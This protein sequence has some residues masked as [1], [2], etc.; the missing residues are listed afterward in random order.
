MQL[1]HQGLGKVR[2]LDTQSLWIQDAV[3]ERRVRLEKVLGT[4]NPADMFTKHIDGTLREKL[5]KK[6]GLEQRGGRAATAPQLVRGPAGRAN[7]DEQVANIDLFEIDHGDEIY[8]ECEAEVERVGSRRQNS[9]LKH[10]SGDAPNGAKRS[11]ASRRRRHT[12]TSSITSFGRSSTIS[13][14]SSIG[15]RRFGSARGIAPHESDAAKER[16]PRSKAT[17]SYRPGGERH[18]LSSLGFTRAVIRLWQRSCLNSATDIGVNR[19]EE[20]FAARVDRGEVQFVCLLS[21]TTR[22]PFAFAGDRVRP[23][24]RRDTYTHTT[25]QQSF[26][27]HGAQGY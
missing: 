25:D 18:P 2:H 12:I 10:V 23:M 21:T 13:Y 4:E 20:R 22:V 5:M 27:W 15:S 24:P 1:F 19:P 16:T 8:C 3:R 11:S 7:V 6:I 9:N 14:S 26:T 17:G